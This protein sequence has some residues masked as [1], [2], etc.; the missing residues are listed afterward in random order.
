[1]YLAKAP[2]QLL[3]TEPIRL[4]NGRNDV[5][6]ARWI[7]PGTPRAVGS[8]C[9]NSAP[10]PLFRQNG[11]MQSN[12][13]PAISRLATQRLQQVYGQRLYLADMY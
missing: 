10:L 5:W 8:W 3:G 12:A 13:S 9:G 1:M 7:L 6:G 11:R 4:S 2:M